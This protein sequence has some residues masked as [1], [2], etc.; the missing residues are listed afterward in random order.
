[1]AYFHNRTSVLESIDSLLQK[2]DNWLILINADPDAMACSLALRRLI[3]RKVASVTIGHINEIKRPD[4][5]SMIRLLGINMIPWSSEIA[6]REKSKYQ[7]FAI[8]DSQ[9]HHSPHFSGINFDIIIDHH[10]VTDATEKDA[11]F[12]IILPELG[13]AST[14]MTELLYNSKIKIG[15]K[16]ATALQYGIRTDTGSLG[17]SAT[18]LDFRAYHYLNRFADHSILLRIIKSEYLPQ[19]LPFFAQAIENLNACSHGYL[20]YVGNIQNP[21]ILVVVADFFQKVHNFNWVAV[22]GVY[23]KTLVVIFRGVAEDDLGTLANTAFKDYGSA[24]GHQHMARAEVP[25]ENAEQP[26]AEFIQNRMSF[27]VAQYKKKKVDSLCDP[28]EDMN[29]D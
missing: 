12:S 2:E 23:N 5:L 13:S 18:E 28:T 20:S 3:K 6:E 19:W 26:Y 29:L 4:N 17:S 24:G 9:P 25:L 21:D 1:M 10:P 14:F 22:G 15:K 8:L 11:P 27:A 7:K 16:L